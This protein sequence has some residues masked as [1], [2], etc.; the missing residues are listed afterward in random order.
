MRHSGAPFSIRNALQHVFAECHARSRAAHR[1]SQRRDFHD[2]FVTHL[3]S[4]S[5]SPDK[6]R[7]SHHKLPRSH[8][9]PHSG[10]AE[11]SNRPPSDRETTVVR[12]PLKSAKH[13]FGA[14]V[15]RGSRP[16]HEDTFQAGTVEIPAFAKKQPVSISGRR[17]IS[18]NVGSTRATGDPQVFYFAVFDGHGGSECSEFLRDRLHGYIEE[19]A[20][21]F[22]LESSLHKQDDAAESGEGSG[23]MGE[24]DA[25]ALQKSLVT[26]WKDTVGG[27]FKRFRPEYFPAM[28]SDDD[29]AVTSN[30][31]ETVLTYAFLKA[32]LD[33]TTAQAKKQ[34]ED[35]SAKEKAAQKALRDKVSN[36]D[37]VVGDRPLNDGDMLFHPEREASQNLSTRPAPRGSSPNLDDAIGGK[38]RFQG[39]S[40][41]SIALISTPTP[42]PFWHP[43]SPSTLTAAHVGDTRILLCKTDDG[44]AVPVTQNHHPSMPVEARRLRRYAT[45]FVT[46]SFGEERILGLANTRAFG[47]IG[48]KRIGVSAEPQITTVHLPPAGYSFIVLMSDGISGHLEDQEIVD[49]VK[50]AKTPE[51]ASK[52]LVTFAVETAGEADNATALVV[53]LGGWERRNEGGNG[54]LGTK[55]RRTFRQQEADNPRLRRQ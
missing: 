27:Y 24:Q 26:S 25:E 20:L 49:I 3:P 35:A 39:G 1:F 32:D 51:Q 16:Y 42:T 52:D 22:G 14:G 4:S 44:S 40:T 29:P 53:R 10:P 41:A 47:D 38:K 54:S 37:P 31:I 7:A 48:S 12:I 23:I 21:L 13:H 28:A 11:R 9:T 50:E 17:E 30:S 34:S 15:S 43:N 6:N 2:Y 36:D 5:L 8:S 45:S 55:E 18:Q 33:F 46:D 19:A